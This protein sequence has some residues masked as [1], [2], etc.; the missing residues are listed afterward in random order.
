MKPEVQILAI[1]LQLPDKDLASIHAKLRL[2]KLSLKSLQSK[3]AR[4]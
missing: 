3:N 2:P 1:Q 4:Q